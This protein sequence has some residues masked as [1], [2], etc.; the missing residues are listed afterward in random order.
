MNRP[1]HFHRLS[2]RQDGIEADENNDEDAYGRFV[3]SP[4]VKLRADLEWHAMDWRGRLP[5]GW[6]ID[7]ALES[8]RKV[9]DHDA[10]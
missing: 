4:E 8:Y 7:A 5:D 2:E 3:I 6:N 1:S 10:L 9:R